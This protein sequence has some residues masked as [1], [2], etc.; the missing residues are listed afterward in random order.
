[1]VQV[2]MNGRRVVLATYRFF[3]VAAKGFYVIVFTAICR[4]KAPVGMARFLR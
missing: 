4:L 3:G 2:A 1:M